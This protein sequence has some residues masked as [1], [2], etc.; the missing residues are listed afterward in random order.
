MPQMYRSLWAYC[1]TLAPPPPP[2]ILGVPTSAARRLHVHT[3]RDILA[4][5]GGAVGEIVGR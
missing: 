1:T 2:V 5:K 4:A 3:A